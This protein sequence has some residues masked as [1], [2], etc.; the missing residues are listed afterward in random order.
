MKNTERIISD[1]NPD[2]L[3]GFFDAFI[4]DRKIRGLSPGSIRFY[5]QKLTPFLEWCQS[6]GLESIT[7]L[8]PHHLRLFL[9]WLQERGN[10]AGGRHAFYRA[11]R[12]FLNFYEDET[13]PENWKNPIKQVSAPKVPDAPLKPVSLEAFAK[14]VRACDQSTFYGSR[15]RAM[16][17][18]LLDSG[19]RA[20]E[21]IGIVLGDVDLISGSIQI[22][23]GK[24]GKVRTVLIGR[25][26][27]KAIRFWLRKRGK[28]P[29]PLFV[30]KDGYRLTYKGLRSILERR[31]KAS[32]VSGVSL[33]DFRRAFCLSQLQAGTPE[34]TIARLMGH[35]NTQLI[36]LYARQTTRHL[37]EVF[38]SVADS[39]L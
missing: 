29:G 20:S 5:N 2:N 38:H 4:L 39:E 11:L 37:I 33:H 25:K 3:G 31:L 28:G 1:F 9:L 22:Q 15:H 34:T 12:A 8:T 27:K 17:L 23:K 14:L 36:G 30:K 18:V 26:S 6:Q 35:S 24:G 13:E 7:Q 16:F 10:S 19:V 32:G 21:L